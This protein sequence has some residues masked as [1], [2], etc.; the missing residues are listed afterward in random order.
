[1]MQ[2]AEATRYQISLCKLQSLCSVVGSHYEVKKLPSAGGV[3]VEVFAKG[4]PKPAWR[5]RNV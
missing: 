4:T 5:A 2:S 3:L 1:M